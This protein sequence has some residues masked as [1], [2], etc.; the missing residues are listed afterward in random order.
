MTAAR[1]LTA[2]VTEGVVMLGPKQYYREKRDLAGYPLR[3]LLF[4]EHGANYHESP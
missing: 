3:P 2:V 1:E 4:N